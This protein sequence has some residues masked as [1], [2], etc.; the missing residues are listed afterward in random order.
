[1]VSALR[2][3][4]FALC[5]LDLD[6]LWVTA[7]HHSDLYQNTVGL[8]ALHRSHLHQL[9]ILFFWPTVPF[10]AKVTGEQLQLRFC[11]APRQ[12]VRPWVRFCTPFLRICSALIGPEWRAFS[13]HFMIDSTPRHGPFSRDWALHD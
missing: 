5:A 6:R 2:L 8:L 3:T 11:F 9:K 1:M 10:L 7:W 13:A 4:G 12:H